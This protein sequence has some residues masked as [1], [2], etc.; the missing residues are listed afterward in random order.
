[1]VK[2]TSFSSRLSLDF[3]PYRNEEYRQS[4]SYLVDFVL[5]HAMGIPFADGGERVEIILMA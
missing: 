5:S 3:A 1:M 4:S 2:S